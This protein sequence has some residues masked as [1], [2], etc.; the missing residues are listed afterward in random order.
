MGIARLSGILST[1]PY[2]TFNYDFSKVVQRDFQLVLLENKIGFIQKKPSAF[3]WHTL[4]MYFHYISTHSCATC[5]YIRCTHLLRVMCRWWERTTRITGLYST[6][7]M[8]LMEPKI[9]I[10]VSVVMW[11]NHYVVQL[12]LYLVTLDSS[13]N[14]MTYVLSWYSFVTVCASYDPGIAL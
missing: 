9:T 8:A 2:I 3:R 13:S 7:P 12:V 4:S 5:E 14:K 1:Q 6:S 11:A 10:Y